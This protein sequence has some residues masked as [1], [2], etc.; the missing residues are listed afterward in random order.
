MHPELVRYIRDFVLYHVR[1]R[2]RQR[3]AEAFGISRQT[4]WRYLEY[5]HDGSTV[6]SAV[7][8]TVGGSIK[9]LEEAWL[10]LIRER[11]LPELDVSELPLSDDLEH[12]L[13]LVCATP[14]ASAE[15]LS[16]FGRI[17]ASTMR[18]RLG[19]LTKR[20]L[21]DSISHRLSALGPRPQRRY[22]P[23]KEGIVAGG[24]TDESQLH[25]LQTYP[26]SR[27]WFR[28]LS[29]RLDAVAVLYHVASLVAEADPLAKPMRVDHYRQ[30]PCDALLTL[31][32]GRSIGLLR[33]GPTLPT[34]NLRF[35]LRSLFRLDYKDRPQV[36]LVLTPSDQATRRAI[37]SLGDPSRHHRMFVATEGEVIAGDV[38]ALVWQQCGSG[39]GNSPP[40]GISP[41]VP[42]SIVVAWTQR[43]AETYPVPSGDPPR[44]DPDALYRSRL[45]ASMPEPS[46]QLES[47]LS[48]QLGRGEKDVL[49]LLAAWPLCT[50]EQLSGLM[51]G[52]TRRR[53]DQVL[54]SLT[55][56][57]L[58]RADGRLHVLTDEGL[59]FLARRD[60]AS[61]S[62]TLSRWSARTDDRR[63]KQGRGRTPV[64]YGTSLRVMASQMEHHAGI[65]EFASALTAEVARKSGYELLDLMPTSRSSAGYWYMGANY[66]VHPDA[67][68]Q[69]GYEGQWHHYLLE[70]ERRATTPKR[71]PAKLESYRRYFRSGWASRDHGGTLP[72]VLFVFETPSGEETFLHVASRLERVPISS[73]NLE[74]LAHTDV[75]GD[76]WRLPPLSPPG[77]WALLSLDR[78]ATCK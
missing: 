16:L 8:R 1:R 11:P 29:E 4:L 47:S 7:M 23:T 33:Q 75:L 66:V 53:A 64:Y 52:V 49:D 40:V 57:G 2:G 3:T 73:T 59:T 48:V 76:A 78:N 74:T 35:L 17:P 5:G 38:E 32:D 39:L 62:L 44:P 43:L 9:G 63:H 55:G 65:T 61:V 6:P 58:V 10:S 25:Y 77:R 12:T 60:R 34:S 20:G 68:F 24:A 37:R 54:S 45:R 14:L 46:R 36:T 41:D 69:L 71:V 70:Y 67:S 18:D 72:R 42:L 56:R 19:R 50:R 15:E 30:G 13:L 21:I 22:F 28:L 31:S 51:G 26:V 27:Q